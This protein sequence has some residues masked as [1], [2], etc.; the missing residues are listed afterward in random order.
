MEPFPA[1]FRAG[2]CVVFHGSW[3][4]AP[5]PQAGDTI[6]F[7]PFDG[8]TPGPDFEV[9]AEGFEGADVLENPGAAVHRPMGIA[10]GVDGEL[11]ISSTVSG[12]VWQVRYVGE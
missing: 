8:A 12:R 4:R 10:E 5:L 9:F 7:V 11:Y 1:R 2:A 3:T 6:V